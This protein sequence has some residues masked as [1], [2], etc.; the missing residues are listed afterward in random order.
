M[1]TNLLLAAILAAALI[2]PAHAKGEWT[3]QDAC[4]MGAEIYESLIVA[5]DA[6]VPFSKVV[7]IT[8]KMDAPAAYREAWISIATEAY[9]HPSDFKKGGSAA[10]YKT[11]MGAE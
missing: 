2:A 10:L 1:K 11:C 4:A 8:R 7:K 3:T 6:G 5:R 9:A